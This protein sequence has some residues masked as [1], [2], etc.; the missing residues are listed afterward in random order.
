MT[1]EYTRELLRV[2]RVEVA[3][4]LQRID[5]TIAMLDRD[6]PSIV[7]SSDQPSQEC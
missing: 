5:H 1:D 7:Y 4:L 3:A 6:Q 2:L